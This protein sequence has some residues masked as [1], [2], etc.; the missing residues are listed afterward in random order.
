MGQWV[1]AMPPYF[2]AS[3][4]KDFVFG[5]WSSRIFLLPLPAPLEVSCFRVR[6]R[7][8][9]LGIFCF[10]FRL[11]IKLFAS[12]FA[13]ASSLFCQNASASFRILTASNFRFLRFLSNCMLT[14]Q[15]KTE[16]SCAENPFQPRLKVVYYNFFYC[17]SI[18]VVL[19]RAVVAIPG[20]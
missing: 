14:A 3:A 15:R 10:R 1:A 6:F 13:S 9:T 11:R 8:L 4:S 16:T 2:Q 5:L 18:L 12:E 7:F 17:R 19:C 20:P